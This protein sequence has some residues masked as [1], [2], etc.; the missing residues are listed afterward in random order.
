MTDGHYFNHSTC[1]TSFGT[2]QRSIFDVL[3]IFDCKKEFRARILKF[4]RDNR[5]F[6][7]LLFLSLDTTFRPAIVVRVVVRL[8]LNN[9]LILCYFFF[10]GGWRY[11]V[12][13]CRN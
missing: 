5:A 7:I 9:H 1:R 13:I 4:A 2:Y 12:Y 11:K 3:N 8:V 6:I 10:G